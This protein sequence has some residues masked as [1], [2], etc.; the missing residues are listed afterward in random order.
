VISAP[1]CWACEARKLISGVTTSRVGAA[2]R[3]ELAAPELGMG[4]LMIAQ[5]APTVALVTTSV[6][7]QRIRPLI[8][9]PYS[10]GY[11]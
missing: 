5:A 8:T 9:S 2:T 4:V 10:S 6:V 1:S 11:S 3:A 7:T